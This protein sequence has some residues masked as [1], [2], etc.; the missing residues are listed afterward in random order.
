MTTA[1]PLNV[2][3][4]GLKF[5]RHLLRTVT[6]LPGARVVAVADRSAPDAA[7][8]AR[9]NG[10]KHYTEGAALV[11]DAA[12]DVVILALMPGKREALLRQAL[13]AGKAVWLEKPFAADLAAARTLAAEIQAAGAERRVMVGF[14]FRFHP[15]VTR[16]GDLLQGELGPPWIANGDYSFD[17][18]PPAGHPVWSPVAGGGFVNENSCHLFDV[19]CHLL[20]RPEAV[21]AEAIR[22][23]GLP[24]D[25]AV[26]LTV[27][28]D[29]GAVAA[30]T[31]GCHAA[32]GRADFPRLDL[33]TARGTAR[34]LGRGHCWETLA[35]A[36]RTGGGE[37]VEQFVPETLGQTR[38]TVA[39]TRFLQALAAG[40]APPATIAHGVRAVALADA[41]GRAAAGGGRVAVVV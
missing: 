26:A 39:W 16:L 35:W 32:P 34:L 21:Q 33:V 20:G 40:E 14:S 28:F 18:A 5:G 17:Y 11:A 36:R 15:A 3:L 29:G 25:E 30:L 6:G 2:G 38:Y 4:V 9:Q 12:V 19:L 31:V 10:L 41:V 27:R 22:P 23:A 7:A 24:G 37:T 13:A 8:L 1:R